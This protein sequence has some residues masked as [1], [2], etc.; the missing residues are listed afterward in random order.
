MYIFYDEVWVNLSVVFFARIILK[1]IMVP[2]SVVINLFT[3]FV[4]QSLNKT[5]LFVV[6]Y[7]FQI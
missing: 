5:S 1:I 4:H 3:Y 6:I 2:D 7:Y